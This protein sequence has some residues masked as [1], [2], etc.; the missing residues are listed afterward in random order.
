MNGSAEE[1]V[2]MLMLSLSSSKIKLK[3]EFVFLNV[4]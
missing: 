2:H 4:T 3:G 1:L